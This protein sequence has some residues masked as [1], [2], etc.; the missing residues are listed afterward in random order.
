MKKKRCR[1]CK[2]DR[3][4]VC[5]G[6]TSAAA[7]ASTLIAGGAA[8][9][10]R[11]AGGGAPG[12][13]CAADL[14]AAAVGGLGGRWWLWWSSE[15]L[16]ACRPCA[17]YSPAASMTCHL[18][19]IQRSFMASAMKCVWS[20]ASPGALPGNMHWHLFSQLLAFPGSPKCNLGY[21]CTWARSFV[22][23]AS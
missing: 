2:R 1:C 7:A 5:K 3:L 15:P 16:A 18:G 6:C 4:E 19:H 11:P 10:C 12:C 17:W 13:S 14:P 22:L 20:A 9:S 23:E 21:V 8:A